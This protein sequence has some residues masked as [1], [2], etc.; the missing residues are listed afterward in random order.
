MLTQ[1]RVKK[2]KTTNWKT[3]EKAKIA[4]EE[5]M[6]VGFVLVSFETDEDGGVLIQIKLPLQE[7]KPKED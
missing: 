4:V 6:Q 5:L 2:M 7:D 1:V 3:F